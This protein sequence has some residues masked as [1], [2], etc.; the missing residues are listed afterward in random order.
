[1]RVLGAFYAVAAAA[2]ERTGSSCVPADTRRFQNK[3]DGATVATTIAQ[4]KT[5]ETQKMLVVKLSKASQIKVTNVPNRKA[6]RRAPLRNG[7]E[8]EHRACTISENGN[9][10][11]RSMK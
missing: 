9:A 6:V 4:G 11:T 8:Y 10:T 5:G 3:I 1:M 2:R 7:N